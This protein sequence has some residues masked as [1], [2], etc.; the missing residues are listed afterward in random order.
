MEIETEDTLLT[1]QE[2]ADLLNVHIN[3]L[4]KMEKSGEFVPAR[5]LGKRRRYLRSEVVEFMRE[6]E[7]VKPGGDDATAH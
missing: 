4:R 5:R 2:V 6:L 3:T 1:R 7:T